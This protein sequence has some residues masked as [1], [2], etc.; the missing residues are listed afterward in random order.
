MI[1]ASLGAALSGTGVV[2]RRF[3]ALAGLRQRRAAEEH[4][5][6]GRRCS[7]QRQTEPMF[8]VGKAALP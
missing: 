4:Q 3:G 8:G 6:R 1:V 7:L 2:E 5:L